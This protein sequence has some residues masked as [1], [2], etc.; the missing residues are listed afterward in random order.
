MKLE[1]LDATGGGEY[2]NASPAN[3]IRL[4]EFSDAEKHELIKDIQETIILQKQPLQLHRLNYIHPV[5]CSVTLQV[6][7]NDDCLTLTGPGN[8]FTCF[9]SI[10]SFREMIKIMKHVD[11]GHNWLT[12]GEYLDEP[13]FLISKWGSW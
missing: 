10:S 4:S 6:S 12:P 9:L 2:P 1:Y 5:N 8:A 7:D 11:D 3:L 13:A